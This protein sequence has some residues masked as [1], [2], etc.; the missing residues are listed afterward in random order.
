MVELAKSYERYAER[1]QLLADARAVVAR[2]CGC[3]MCDTHL[4]NGVFHCSIVV[5]EL[6]ATS[7]AFGEPLL[8]NTWVHGQFVFSLKIG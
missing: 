6:H 1:N 4:I 7:A 3:D 2:I 5:V 8:K